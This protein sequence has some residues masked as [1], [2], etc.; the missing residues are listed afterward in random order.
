ME[1]NNWL[2]FVSVWIVATL[3]IGPN[4]IHTVTV[5]IEHGMAKAMYTVAGIGLASVIHTIAALVGISTLLAIAPSL[6]WFLKIVGACYLAWLGIRLW[7][8]SPDSV[9]AKSNDNT[10][11]VAFLTRGCL[12]S[13]SNPKAIASYSAIF[14]SFVSPER[15]VLPQLVVLMP[16]ATI[17]V[18][19]VYAGYAAA[20]SPLKQWLT[21]PKRWI[22]FNR[23]AGC[24]F[25]G[26]AGA[27]LMSSKRV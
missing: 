16:T 2:V 23:T 13:L 15:D 20:A 8:Q 21:N 10:A 3:P 17:I 1:I 18:L 25:I 24:M 26:F 5:T 27:L 14:V 11:P 4:V 22:A 19:L 7:R 9:T 6:Y 12:I